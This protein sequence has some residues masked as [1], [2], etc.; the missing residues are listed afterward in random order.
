MRLIRKSQCL[1]SKEF[2]LMTLSPEQQIYRP[3]QNSN[4]SKCHLSYALLGLI[5][6][7]RI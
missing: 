7:Q 6:K 3:L 1:V 4:Y 5:P 2:S